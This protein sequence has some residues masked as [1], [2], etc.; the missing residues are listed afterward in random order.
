MK[1]LFIAMLLLA[2]SA[3]CG[4]QTFDEWFSQKKTQ[5]KYLVTQIAELELYTKDLEKGYQI[6]HDGLATINDIRHGEFDLH[7]NYFNSLLTANASI[8]ASSTV[9]ACRQLIQYIRSQVSIA[10]AA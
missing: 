2:A 10:S 3:S 5:I 1:F 4:A 7:N 6:A 9:S 8:S